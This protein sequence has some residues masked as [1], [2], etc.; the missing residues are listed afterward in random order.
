VKGQRKAVRNGA[1]D[2]Q[3]V[4]RQWVRACGILDDRP[5]AVIIVIAGVRRIRVSKVRYFLLRV[6]RDR[7]RSD[8]LD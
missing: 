6:R 4:A 5:Q 2:G 8:L 1:C 3:R 7:K